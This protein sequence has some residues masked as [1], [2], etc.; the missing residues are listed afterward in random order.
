M[1]SKEIIIK[2]PHGLHTRIAAMMV[3]KASELMN[4]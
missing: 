4:K 2:D 3:N 1:F